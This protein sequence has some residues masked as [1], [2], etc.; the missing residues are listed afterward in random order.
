MT[1]TGQSGSCLRALDAIE[2][3]GWPRVEVNLWLQSAGRVRGLS[4]IR[5]IH[6]S[7]V[8]PCSL[9]WRQGR[10]TTGTAITYRSLIANDAASA[11]G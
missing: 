8:P 1:C 5:A 4:T 11:G 6:L 2:I 10:W 3:G 9:D 7:Q